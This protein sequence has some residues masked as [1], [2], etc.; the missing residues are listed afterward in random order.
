MTLIGVK[1]KQ[2]RNL[3]VLL[4]VFPG[5]RRTIFA[6]F[7]ARRP[8]LPPRPG[9]VVIVRRKR[10]RVLAVTQVT[11]TRGG[12]VEHRTEVFAAP[13][14]TRKRAMP[15]N[16]VAMPLGDSSVVADFLRY[17]ALVRT[18]GGDPD[19]WLARLDES[20]GDEADVRF[21]RRIRARLRCEPELLTA[22][23]RMVDTTPFWG[24]VSSG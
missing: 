2:Q 23:R 11:E 1:T 13:K 15:R 4:I 7:A 18:Y 24:L 8:W 9:E 20:G 10:L 16:V 3:Y 5:N 6:R 14:R 17:H 22:I 19:A 21:A 12:V